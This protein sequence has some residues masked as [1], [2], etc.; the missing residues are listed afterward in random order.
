[1]ARLKSR[2]YRY[3][4]EVRLRALDQLLRGAPPAEVA[5]NLGVSIQTVCNWRARIRQERNTK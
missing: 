4:A 5:R 2:G 1:M 3:P